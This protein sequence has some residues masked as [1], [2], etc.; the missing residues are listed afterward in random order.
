MLLLIL[1]MAYDVAVIIFLIMKEIDDIWCYDN[2]LELR[3]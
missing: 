3:G 2:K 1:A